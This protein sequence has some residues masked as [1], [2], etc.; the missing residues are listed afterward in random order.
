MKLLRTLIVCSALS[1]LSACANLQTAFDTPDKVSPV[2]RLEEQQRWWNVYQDPLMNPLINQL[3]EQ[4]LDIQIAQTRIAESRGI[5]RGS[6][7]GFFPDISLNGNAQRSNRQI[8]FDKSVTITQGGFDAKWELDVFGQTAATVDAAES[9]VQSR[10]AGSQDVT[11]SVIAELIRAVIRYRQAEETLVETQALLKTQDE[12]VELLAARANA[13]LIDTSFASR[14][15]AERDQTATRLPQA[16]AAKDAAQYQIERLLGK[17]SGTM[18][19]TLS[20]SPAP[21]TV[22]DVNPA[23][24][25]SL[26]VMRERPDIR[27]ARADLLAAQADVTSAERDLW[28]RISVGAFFGVQDSPNAVRIAENPIWS[29]ASGIAM[30]L[31]NFGRLQ[32][33]VDASNARAKAASLTYENA[34]LSALQET[35]TALSDY[36]NG[37]NAVAKQESALKRRKETVGYASARFKQGLTDMTDLTTAQSE[38]NSATLLLIDR[39]ADAAIA[40]ARLQKALGVSVHAVPEKGE[41]VE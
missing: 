16:Q 36:L 4:N 24:N 38:L 28:P 40:Y 29:L 41:R 14:A 12:Q 37:I 5:L 18:G 22:P 26:D 27:A 19:E 13:G 11:N 33:A 10:I 17:A 35:K 20:S 15:E 7:A 30:P 39:K 32:G 9:R 1:T 31:L 8:G 3:L 34:S 6:N 25:L 21:L 2:I 23:L